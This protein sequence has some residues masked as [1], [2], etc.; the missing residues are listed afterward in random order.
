MP[1]SETPPTYTEP[2]RLYVNPVFALSR[3]LGGADADVIAAGLLV[4]FKAS[5]DRSVIR[6]NDKYQLVC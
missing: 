4:D 5:K 1:R 3:T 2:R 6:S